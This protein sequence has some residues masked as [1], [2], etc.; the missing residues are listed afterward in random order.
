MC[1]Y[2]LIS[3]CACVISVPINLGLVELVDWENGATE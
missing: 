3:V 1:A 2:T